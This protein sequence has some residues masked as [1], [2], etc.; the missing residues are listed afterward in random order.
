VAYVALALLVSSVI[1][2]SW[3]AHRTGQS[4][5]GCCAPPDPRDDLRMRDALTSLEAHRSDHPWADTGS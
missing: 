1:G 2:L 3:L 5:R 4:S